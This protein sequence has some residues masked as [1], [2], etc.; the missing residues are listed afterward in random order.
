MT[1]PHTTAM[2]FL[3]KIC[4]L[5]AFACIAIFVV[6]FISAIMGHWLQVFIYAAPLALAGIFLALIEKGNQNGR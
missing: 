2:P 6:D 4:A 5:L 3:L 1:N